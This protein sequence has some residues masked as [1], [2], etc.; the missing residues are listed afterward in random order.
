MFWMAERV[1]VKKSQKS[2]DSCGF[3]FS[4]FSSAEAN[5]LYGKL[6]E[7]VMETAGHSFIITVCFPLLFSRQTFS[8]ID[9]ESSA[10]PRNNI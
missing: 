7:Y 4:F 5:R 8:V 2:S 3:L 6:I 1:S 10:A 9:T